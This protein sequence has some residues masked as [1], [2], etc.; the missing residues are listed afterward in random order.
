MQLVVLADEEE[1]TKWA[2]G[3]GESAAVHSVT[4]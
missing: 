1:T 2:E 3:L 4:R